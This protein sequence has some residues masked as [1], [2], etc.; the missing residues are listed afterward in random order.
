MSYISVKLIQFQAFL[1]WLYVVKMG[2]VWQHAI[3][4]L[5]IKSCELWNRK[6]IYVYAD[7]KSWKKKIIEFSASFS[8][9]LWTDSQSQPSFKNWLFSQGICQINVNK[10]KWLFQNQKLFRHFKDLHLAMIP[11]QERN[12]NAP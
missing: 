3:N 9:I 5:P 11:N 12:E 4:L 6:N 7:I 8:N 1:L 2:L 10:I